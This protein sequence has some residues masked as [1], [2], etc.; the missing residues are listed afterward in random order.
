M[1]HHT[2][3]HFRRA[4]QTWTEALQSHIAADK[5][6]FTAKGLTKAL[7]K[8]KA[9]GWSELSTLPLNRVCSI[10]TVFKEL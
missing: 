8:T 3:M 1:E 9:A 6:H 2:K 4:C 7:E 10:L 5:V